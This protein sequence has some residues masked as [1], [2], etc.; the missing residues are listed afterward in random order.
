MRWPPE[1]V[2]RLKALYA[3]GQSMTAIAATLTAEGFTVTRSAVVGKVHR[4][5]NL[6]ARRKVVVRGESWHATRKAAAGATSRI[7]R[8]AVANKIAAGSFGAMPKIERREPPPLPSS[9]NLSILDLTHATCKWPYGDGPFLFCGV[10][11]PVEGGP[12]CEHHAALAVGQ[13]TP[14]ERSAVRE[15]ARAA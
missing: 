12:Y 6:P 9:L 5:G 11:K 2:A 13:G 8:S 3:D 10:A 4:D 15:A 7:R 1:I 14:S